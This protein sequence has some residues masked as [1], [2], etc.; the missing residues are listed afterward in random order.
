[1]ASSARQTVCCTLKRLRCKVFL[2]TFLVDGQ[3]LY[4]MMLSLSAL[5]TRRRI[6]KR[7]AASSSTAAASSSM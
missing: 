3:A 2:L 7:P 4:S 6:L 1:M 5:F